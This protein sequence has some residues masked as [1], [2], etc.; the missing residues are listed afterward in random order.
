MSTDEKELQLGQV[1]G[2][3]AE[4]LAAKRIIISGEKCILLDT[5]ASMSIDIEPGKTRMDALREIVKNIQGNAPIFAF[6][7]GCVRLLGGIPN[8]MGGTAMHTAFEVVKQEGFRHVLLITDGEP[9]SEAHALRAAQGLSIQIM[10]VGGADKPEFL[11]KLAKVSGSYCTVD[12]LKE[13]KK[14]ETKIQLFLNKGKSEVSGE[15]KG[16]IC[17]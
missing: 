3:L 16:P 9:D 7:S 10:Y 8:P 6:S 14:L 11:D 4:R 2:T 1:T 17:L 15:K 13:G 12:D 5:S